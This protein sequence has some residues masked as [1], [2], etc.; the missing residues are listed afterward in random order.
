MG[1]HEFNGTTSL[2][3][4]N[5]VNSCGISVFPNPVESSTFIRFEPGPAFRSLALYNTA[6]NLIREAPV[7]SHQREIEWNMLFPDLTPG[8][9]IL[10]ANGEK[11]DASLKIII[12]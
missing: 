5:R 2:D 10:R 6:G 12:H 7:S 9:Y 8:L 4:M 11:T 1:C 3:A